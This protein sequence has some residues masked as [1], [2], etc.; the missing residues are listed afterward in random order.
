VVAGIIISMVRTRKITVEVPELLLHRAQKQSGKGITGTVRQGLELL[1]AAQACDELAAL[2]GKIR[3]SIDLE[4]M[5]DDR[6]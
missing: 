6:N 3:F 1:A 4:T 2:R 5:R